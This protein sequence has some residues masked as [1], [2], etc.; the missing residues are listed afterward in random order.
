MSKHEAI[1]IETEWAVLYGDGESEPIASPILAAAR[2]QELRD[3]FARGESS[4]LDYE[5]MRV[6]QR[7][8]EDTPAR[9]R[10]WAECCQPQGAPSAPCTY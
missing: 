8:I 6:V 1:E 5:P 10:A 7:P 4:P 3:G 9:W 2:I